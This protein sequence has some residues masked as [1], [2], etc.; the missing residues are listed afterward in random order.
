MIMI[1]K[2]TTALAAVRWSAWLG[3]L[4]LA[5]F[6]GGWMGYWYGRTYEL[7]ESAKRQGCIP[8]EMTW[9]QFLERK[10]P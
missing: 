3:L 5:L 1:E 8:S 2:L 10:Q 9:E 6:L 7:Y 4:A